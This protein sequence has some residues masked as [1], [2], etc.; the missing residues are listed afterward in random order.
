MDKKIQEK[1]AEAGKHPQDYVN[2]IAESAKKLW[3]LMD[4]TYDDFIQT[5]QER[6]TKAVEKI[7]QKFLDN[8]DIYKGEYE[9]WYCTPCESFFTETQLVDGNC[10][11]CGRPVHKVK[12][13]SYFFNMKKYADRLLAYYEENLEFIEPESRKK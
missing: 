10:P 12:E 7:F 13:E 3:A 4:I 9:G 5:T 1:A 2:E 11:D 6:H 8:G